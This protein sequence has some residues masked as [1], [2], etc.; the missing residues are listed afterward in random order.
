MEIIEILES[1]QAYLLYN[2]NVNQL[3]APIA[4]QFG[5]PLNP[6]EKYE[7]C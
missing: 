1:I 5:I 3:L 6:K 4:E 2:L 7:L